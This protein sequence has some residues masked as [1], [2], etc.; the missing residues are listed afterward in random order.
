MLWSMVGVLL[1]VA[2]ADPAILREARSAQSRFESVR[3]Q[4]LPRHRSGSA[5]RCDAHIGRFCYFYDSTEADA[6]PEPGRILQARAQLL[7]VLYRAARAHSADGWVAGQRVRSLLEAGRPDD[8]I[9]AARDC[10]ADH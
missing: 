10:A 7:N 3:R 6:V 5:D 1:Q 9:T 8:A 4:H 2:A